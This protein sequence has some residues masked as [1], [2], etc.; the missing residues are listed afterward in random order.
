MQAALVFAAS[1]SCYLLTQQQILEVWEAS[2]YTVLRSGV[3]DF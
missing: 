3:D 2:V 1:F